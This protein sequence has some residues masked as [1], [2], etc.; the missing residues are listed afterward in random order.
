M[1]FVLE[2]LEC[3]VALRQARD[4]TSHNLRQ[5]GKT[6]GTNFAQFRQEGT[7]PINIGIKK[8]I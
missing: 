7:I 8:N 1:R 5:A 2:V 4:L 6:Q 3:E